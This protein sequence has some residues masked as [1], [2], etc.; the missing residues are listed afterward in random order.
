MKRSIGFF[1][2]SSFSTLGKAGRTG[3]MKAQCF[4]TSL[5]SAPTPSGQMAPSAIQ[6]SISAISSAGNS[7]PIGMRGWS[8]RPATL[9]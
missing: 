3:G 7:L 9:R 8:L 2:Q 5:T 4:S 6:L 1:T